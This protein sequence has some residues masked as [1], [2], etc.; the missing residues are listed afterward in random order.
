MVA[1]KTHQANNFLSA[2]E[3]VPAAVLFYGSDSGLV[4]E[5]AAELA[6]RLA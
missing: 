5:R 2:V 4:S 3:R 6:K 1:V